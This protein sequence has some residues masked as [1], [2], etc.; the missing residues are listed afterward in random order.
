MKTEETVEQALARGVRVT[1]LPAWDRQ[2]ALA[3]VED[4][5]NKWRRRGALKRRTGI[6]RISAVRRAAAKLP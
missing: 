1:V 4:P 6:G 2:A 5:A 3:A